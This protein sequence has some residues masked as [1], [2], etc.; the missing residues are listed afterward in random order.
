MFVGISEIGVSVIVKQLQHVRIIRAFCL[1]GGLIKCFSAW[2]DK[3]LLVLIC[4]RGYYWI[5]QNSIEAN[6]YHKSM[7][8]E[9]FLSVPGLQLSSKMFFVFSEYP[10]VMYVLRIILPSSVTVFLLM[11]VWLW[12]LVVIS[13]FLHRVCKSEVLVLLS[14]KYDWTKIGLASKVLQVELLF[15]RLESFA[16]HVVA[17][18]KQGKDSTNKDVN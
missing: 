15:A 12:D 9:Y 3:K 14:S 1:S 17:G 5:N 8:F 6:S 7:Y 4:Y 16:I 18:W 10:N 2:G 11:G 13:I